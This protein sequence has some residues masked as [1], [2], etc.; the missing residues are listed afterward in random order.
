MP[1]KRE[2]KD[3]FTFEPADKMIKDNLW[4]C[5]I[6][7][8]YQDNAYYSIS[9]NE[10]VVPEKEQFKN[11]EAFWGTVFH[12]MVHSTGAENQLN[13]FKPAQGFGTLEYSREE[14]VAELGSALVSQRY[15]MTKNIKEDSAAYLK[16]W[17]DHLK[18]SPQFLKTTLFDVKKATSM[19][20]Q[21]I[22]KIALDLQQEASQENKIEQPKE[23][24]YYSSVAYLQST[25]DTRQFEELKDKQ[26]YDGILNLAK[27]F[28]DG[29][30]INEQYTYTSPTQNKGDSVLVE[31]KD[32]I[33]VY[34]STV[35]GTFDIMLKFNEQ[36]IRDHINR[37]GV[38]NA[39]DTLKE[40]AKD[41]AAE[42][43]SALTQEKIPA[44][45]MPN[46]E[47]LYVNYNRNSDTL[48]VGSVT[49]AGFAAMHNFSYDHNSSLDSNLQDVHEKLRE[50]EEYQT[51]ENEYSGG[52]RR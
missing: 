50:M 36:E 19:I 33:V 51:E 34:N 20:T 29:N 48:D 3:N 32:F 11:N 46:G 14:L 24:I 43:F 23:K 37:Y 49:N 35:G 12:E 41:M 42:Q 27:E 40:V 6:K 45:E 9:K 16:S 30:G 2:N 26:D 44:F 18:E 1:P 7:P 38:D 25:D 21:K 4:I 47:V 5:P 15:G 17:L 22:D 52:M 28:Y 10:I 31:D 8:Q 39:G 13:R